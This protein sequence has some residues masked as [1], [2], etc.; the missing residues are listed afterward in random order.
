M[1]TIKS[2]GVDEII[3]SVKAMQENVST[4]TIS[5]MMDKI[6]ERVKDYIIEE[7]KRYGSIW[8][9]KNGNLEE[10]SGDDVV[11][12]K[13]IG[14]YIITI[15][16]ETQPFDMISY[17]SL[18]NPNYSGLPSEV[19]PYFFIEFGF[20][21]TGGNNQIENAPKF[22]WR[23]NIRPW[24]NGW[25]FTGRDGSRGNWSTGGRG[26]G[27]ISKL[28]GQ[29]GRNGEFERIVNQIIAEEVRNAKSKR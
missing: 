3:K 24:R 22:G 10:I 7:Y 12:I 28:A 2:T 9:E 21:I 26:V 6:A 8:R 4:A 16:S 20:G 29:N 15:G 17:E 19:N 18:K 25:H 23:Y 27:A 14:S 5:P 11:I 1:V 13:N